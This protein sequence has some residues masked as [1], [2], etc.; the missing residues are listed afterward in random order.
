MKT[1]TVI[2]AMKVILFCYQLWMHI[3]KKAALRVV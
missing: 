3:Y 1:E 2:Y